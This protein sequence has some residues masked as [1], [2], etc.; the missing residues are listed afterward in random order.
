[1]SSVHILT[2][3]WIIYSF[4]GMP[5]RSMFVELISLYP[6]IVLLLP[7][8]MEIETEVFSGRSASR[9]IISHFMPLGRVISSVKNE[10]PLIGLPRGTATV[11][12]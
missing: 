1:M 4:H 11:T 3:T 9:S 5:E 12:S 8:R 6:R 10:P 2:L 7:S